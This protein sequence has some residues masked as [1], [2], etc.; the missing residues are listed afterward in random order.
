MKMIV[1]ERQK[2][3]ELQNKEYYIKD[4]RMGVEAG[5]KRLEFPGAKITVISES[6]LHFQLFFP[7]PGLTWDVHAECDQRAGSVALHSI[8]ENKSER[9][10]P[11]GKAVVFEAQAPV[12]FA[13]PEDDVVCLPL[14]GL[15]SCPRKVHQ[16]KNAD[17]PRLSKIKSQFFNRTQRKAFQVGFLT[18]RRADAQVV[19][20]YAVNTGRLRVK[21]FCDYAGWE[22]APGQKTSTEIFNLAIGTDPYAQLENWADRAAQYCQPRRWEDAPVGWVGWAWV[23]PFTVE[24]YEDVV[25]RNCQAIRKRLAGFNIRYIW[26]SLGNIADATPGDW[27]NWNYN[28]FPGGPHHLKAKLDEMGFQWGLWC[29]LFWM[30]ALLK[31]QVEEL[32]DALLKNADGSLMVVRDEWSYGA[33]GRMPQK[34]RPCIYALDPSHPKSLA[35][36]KKV[37]ET[38]RDW[39]VRYYMLDFLHAGAGN[40][41]NLPYENHH[42]QHLVAG[43]EAYHHALQA[44]REAA[45]AD[46]YF[47]SSSGP[48]VH[49][50][51]AVDAA[52]TGNDFGE[53]RPLYPDSYFYPA[54]YVINSGNFWTGPNGAL[55]NQAAAYY[56]HRKL[57]LN[58]SGNVLTVDKP[59]PLNDARIHATIHALSGGPTMLGDDIDRI[60]AGRL[61]LIKKTLP[62]PR[63]VAF[64]VDLFD[65]V[66][67][68]CPRIFQR[69]IVKPW[70]RF[71]VVAV[72]NFTDDLLRLPVGLSKLGLKDQTPYLIWE[73]WNTEY[74]GRVTGV[75][76][77]IV[78]PRSVNVYRLTEDTG[79]PALL[80]TDMHLLMGEMEIDRCDWDAAAQT[81]SI[82]AVHPA[83]EQGSVFLHA[84]PLL[85]VAN[86]RGH[87]IAKDAR[88]NSLIIRCSSD[89]ASGAAEWKVEFAGLNEVLDMTKLDL[90]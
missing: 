45:G 32:R 72:Y 82:R 48:T 52:R 35:F 67:P 5:G 78:N 33:A 87:W 41:S 65:A 50:A 10:I 16:L 21:A 60:D 42:D 70:G 39:G 74:V 11:L 17:C 80:G 23:D 4:W 25:L 27:L 49:N 13:K 46:T 34:E 59:L 28:L 37:F 84:P 79:T 44:V 64:P 53:G 58:D 7:E 2:C 88:D 20:E 43:P 9:N 85:R 62:R 22:L 31:D 19:H 8:F 55:Q 47:L 29:G 24:R 66:A 1:N 89:F 75:L 15:A 61:E 83:G 76:N 18:F 40:I 56:T 14:E 71:D 3:L 6:P 51:G 63:E 68:D 12:D 36:F 81:L 57:Y 30:C 26:V 38:Y 77:A 90:R 54:T 69:K 73:F 86:P